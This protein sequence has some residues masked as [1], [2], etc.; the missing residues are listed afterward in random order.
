LIQHRLCRCISIC[1]RV[2]G[3]LYRV[4]IRSSHGRSGFRPPDALLTFASNHRRHASPIDRREYRAV[5][6]R[7]A[8]GLCSV[9]PAAAHVRGSYPQS[10]PVYPL[11]LCLPRALLRARRTDFAVPPPSMFLHPRRFTSRGQMGSA[12]SF[13]PFEVCGLAI[14]CLGRPS[15]EFA[16]QF[17]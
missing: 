2:R 3:S 6:W 5:T 13:L 4:F 12:E 7:P 16:I 17:W 15:I 10:W 9:P 1:R 14:G 11:E 8:P